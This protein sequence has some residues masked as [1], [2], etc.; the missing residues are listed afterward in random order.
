MAESIPLDTRHRGWRKLTAFCLASPPLL[1]PLF[2]THILYKCSRVFVLH[3]LP[4]QTPLLLWDLCNLWHFLQS[5]QL[6]WDLASV[7]APNKKSLIPFLNIHSG[8][9]YDHL[10]Q[11]A[12]ISNSATYQKRCGRVM[13]TTKAISK[14]SN[15]PPTHEILVTFIPSILPYKTHSHLACSEAK[16]RWYRQRPK[17]SLWKISSLRFIS[18]TIVKAASSRTQMKTC[19]LFQ[20]QI[21]SLFCLLKARPPLLQLLGLR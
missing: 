17:I 2:L 19:I 21:Q 13:Y 9:N 16:P 14:F 7:M 18:Q 5:T 8:D 20:L 15:Q 10:E 3:V 12:I 6:Q 11:E 1:A 4:S